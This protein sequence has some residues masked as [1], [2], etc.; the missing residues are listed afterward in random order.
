MPSCLSS[1]SKHQ[2]YKSI[3]PLDTGAN[4]LKYWTNPVTKSVFPHF[5]QIIPRYFCAPPGTVE[6]ERVFFA[7]GQILNEFR[8]ALTP[9]NFAG[10]LF[11]KL[12]FCL[13]LNFKKFYEFT[14]FTGEFPR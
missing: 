6:T 11:L 14:E 8:K 1:F 13:I 9:E 10:L 12:L 4:P 5:A 3:R 7:A 2:Q